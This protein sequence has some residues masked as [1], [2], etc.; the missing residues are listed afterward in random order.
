MTKA[1]A[2]RFQTRLN[3]ALQHH[4]AGRSAEALAGYSALLPQEPRHADL[5]YLAGLAAQQLGKLDLA[6]HHATGAVRA[7]PKHA[8]AHLVAGLVLKQQDQPAAALASY[9]R[10]A[11]LQPLNPE[12]YYL[13]GNAQLELRAFV[14]AIADFD[15]ALELRPAYAE[16]LNNRGNALRDLIRYDS[17]LQ[18]YEKALAVRPDYLEALNNYGQTLRDLQ[19]PAESL[20]FIDDALRRF[21]QSAALHNNR[22]VALQDLGRFGQALESFR[23]A[24]HLDPHLAMAHFNEGACRLLMG[25]YYPDG[26]S[27]YEWRWQVRSFNPKVRTFS[28]PPWRGDVPL[29]GQTILL[30]AEQGLGDTLQ[31]C[32]F[33]SDVAARGAKILLEA[34][35]PL[36]DLL[37][38]NFTVD[39]LLSPGDALPPFDVHCP[40]ASLPLALQTT[41]SSLAGSRPYLQAEPARKDQWR[42][43]LGPATRKR[44]GLVWSG[45]AIPNPHR[46]IPFSAL[47]PLWS[48]DV[49]FISLQKQVN[50]LDEPALTAAPV[51]D[52]RRE[53]TDFSDT[54]ALIDLCDL[55]ISVDTS[56]AHLAGAMGKP[57]WVLLLHN[58]DWRWLLEREDNPWYPSARLIRQNRL[59]DWPE[60]VARVATELRRHFR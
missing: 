32:R 34:Q 9:D 40:L 7:N 30:H 36:K 52:F 19:R 26:W 5:L 11:V 20:A 10:A 55:V 50:P 22:G 44:V 23:T 60:V 18:N 24:Q 6:L 21:P 16:A 39:A 13:R 58:P 45:S 47:L 15:R 12:I 31:F 41:L 59:G 57:V 25:Y 54:A 33:I 49:E 37:R 2:E 29:E 28:A 46:S 56:A 35:S 27:K 1:Q 53:I 14:A 42:Q 3:D 48:A 38:H 17:A 43:K 8:G 4:R 51:R